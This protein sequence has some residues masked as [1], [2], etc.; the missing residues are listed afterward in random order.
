MPGF[1]NGRIAVRV[2]RVRHLRTIRSTGA[3]PR[4]T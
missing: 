2:S 1:R 3:A 4:L